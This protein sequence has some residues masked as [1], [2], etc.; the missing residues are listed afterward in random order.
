[1]ASASL[2]NDDGLPPPRLN[3]GCP[4]FVAKTVLMAELTGC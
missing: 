2:M 3:A 1:M 4:W